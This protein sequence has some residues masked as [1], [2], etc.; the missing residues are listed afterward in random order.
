MK[1]FIS[2]VTTAH[3]RPGLSSENSFFY[4]KS[5]YSVSPLSSEV[6]GCSGG[7]PSVT[8]VSG[9]ISTAA[10]HDGI[11]RLSSGL[12]FTSVGSEKGRN[13]TVLTRGK[14]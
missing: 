6:P 7:S 2:T 1:N 5:V 9:V 3:R 10:E 14:L 11:W 4:L 13:K 8:V 12:S